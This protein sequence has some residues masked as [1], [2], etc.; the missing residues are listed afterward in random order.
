VNQRKAFI[1]T[2]NFPVALI[3]Q[4]SAKEKGPGRPGYWDM[5]FWWTRKPLASAR[6]VIAGCLLPADTDPKNF[7]KA[8]GLDQKNPHKCNPTLPKEWQQYFQEKKLLDPFA[9][10]GSIPLEALRL[11]LSVRA[12]E[13]L[14]TAYVFL[15]AVLEYPLKYGVQLVKDV[16]KWGN[17]ITGQLRQDPLI[18]E[19]YD[20]N[21]AVYI[22]SWEVKCP[23]CKNWTPLVGNHWLSRVKNSEG[24]YD[25]VV[26]FEYEKR[27]NELS[28][29]II[30][31]KSKFKN[32]H[33]LTIIGDRVTIRDRTLTVPK[34]NIN[35]KS[36]RATCLNCGGMI[37]YFDPQTMKHYLEKK[38]L[39]REIH[40]RLEW[41][42]RYGLNRF[43]QGDESIAR[44]RLL[45]KVKTVQQKLTFES[46]TMEDQA[47]LTR[48]KKEIEKQK[49]DPDIPYEEF[50]PYKWRHG[51]ISIWGFHQIRKLFNPKQ[52][53][54]LVKLVKLIR[55]V[56]REIV[57]EKNCGEYA[58]A[59]TTYLAIALARYANY[60]SLCT[61]WNAGAQL[62]AQVAHTLSMRGIAMMWN[63][64]EVSPFAEMS[65]TGSWVKNL[66]SALNRSL[67]YLTR[68]HN[69]HG[70]Q[71]F[72]S[73]S[74]TSEGEIVVVVD[75]ATTLAKLDQD[76]RFDLVVTDPPYYD[77]VMYTELSDFYYV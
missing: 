22:G 14:P 45:V 54:V 24:E 37:R 39:P 4:A 73:T 68:L 10:F 2:N 31:L 48:A 43:H 42:V 28:E 7:I 76:V 63:W 65:G 27:G 26:W 55:E 56:G 74:A 46:C 17:W 53:L 32:L 61:V 23:H 1:E 64:G 36:E 77:D 75:D 33:G 51:N 16:E 29:S 13:L 70:Q 69:Y 72:S 9:G 59:I 44:Q 30:D 3:S 50:A 11:G 71:N 12:V 57:R 52:L 19:L 41:Y 62:P 20:D 47:K 21:V 66:S 34:P 8:L 49:G 35:A 67:N 5:V 40:T 18:R 15:K 58:E 38:K 6:A 60:N 25:S